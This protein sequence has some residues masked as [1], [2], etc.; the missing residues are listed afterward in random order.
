MLEIDLLFLQISNESTLKTSFSGGQK[1][2]TVRK[3]VFF[4]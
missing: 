4:G 1:V 3:T 2:D